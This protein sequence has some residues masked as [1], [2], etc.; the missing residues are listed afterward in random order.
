MDSMIPDKTDCTDTLRIS[1]REQ[2]TILA[3]L[4][5][6]AASRKSSERRIDERLRYV[7]HALLFVQVR[8]PGGTT[9]NYLVRTRNLSKTG[10]GFL[11][12][13]FLYSGT[14]CTLSLRTA[15]NKSINVE[16]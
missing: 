3:Q 8:H 10:I 15:D 11:H 4:E 9:S 6:L 7:Q 12:G 5:S 2:G 14:P 16:G 13:T 1:Q